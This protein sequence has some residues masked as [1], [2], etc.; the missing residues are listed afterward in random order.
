MRK[1]GRRSSGGSFKEA[2]R[3]RGSNMTP[4]VKESV[5]EVMAATAHG[6]CKSVMNVARSGAAVALGNEVSR[7]PSPSDVSLIS[8]DEDIA[9]WS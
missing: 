8:I 4:S 1:E 6:G 2:C 9:V 7:H 3:R 5:E